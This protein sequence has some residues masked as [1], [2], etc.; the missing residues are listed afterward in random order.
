MIP[1]GSP[2]NDAE[3]NY[4]LTAETFSD[5]IQDYPE[6]AFASLDKAIR[7]AAWREKAGWRMVVWISDHPNRGPEIASNRETRYWE[8]D[9]ASALQSIEN[10]VWTA[11]NV[12]GNYKPALNNKSVAQAEEILRRSGGFGLPPRRAYDPSSGG[13]SPAEVSKSVKGQ[14]QSI[15]DSGKKVPEILALM[16]EGKDLSTLSTD[17]PGAVLAIDYV[18]NRLSLDSDQIREFFQRSQLVREGWV[19]QEP[20]DPDFLYWVSVKPH[21]MDD[22][23][24]A[25]DDLCETLGDDPPDFDRVKDAMIAMLRSVT[26]DVPKTRGADAE[27]K[28]R[29]Y[30]SKR[31]HVPVEQFSP[32]LSKNIDEF[33]YWYNDTTPQQA[34]EFRHPACKKAALLRMALYGSRVDGGLEDLYFNERTRRWEA[35]KGKALR[36]NWVWGTEHGIHYYYIPLDYVL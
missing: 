18:K 32:L 30:L 20:D 22:M 28:I 25:A 2:N 5:N 4:L 3:L 12:K 8:E 1:F 34:D 23:V 10:G 33:V 21:E 16:A 26:G 29:S 27:T 9:V 31:L 17:L 19:R 14:L 36:F 15:L 11:I 24:E 7:E 13:E 35:H 6:A